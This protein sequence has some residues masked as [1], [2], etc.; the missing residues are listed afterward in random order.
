VR[1]WIGAAVHVAGDIEITHDRPWAIVARVPIEGGGTA[2][3]KACSAVQSFEPRLTAALSRRWP[4][5]VTEVLAHD[6]ERA[7]LLLADAGT[8]VVKLANSP[9]IWLRALPRYAELQRGEVGRVPEHLAHGVPDLRVAHLP[10]A[11]ARLVDLDLPL[12]EHDVA[13]LRAFEPEFGTLCAALADEHPVASIQHDDLHLWNLFVDGPDTRVIDWGDSSI[14]DPFWSLFV[15]FRFLEQVNGLQPGDP[16]FAR[17][18]DA[19]LEPWGRG[20]TDKFDRALRVGAFA[21]AIASMRGRVALRGREQLLFDE[22][23][24]LILRRALAGAPA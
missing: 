12:E 13:R 15:T 5:Y 19:Y 24:A 20:L 23:F 8:S 16:W 14:G 7:W 9:E 10:S 17:L 21:H 3:F 4:S 2:W 22:D 18:R 1:A 11:Y 6:P